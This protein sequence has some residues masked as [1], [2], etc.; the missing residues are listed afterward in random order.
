MGAPTKGGVPGARRIRLSWS[1]SRRRASGLIGSRWPELK[2]DP[3]PLARRSGRLS[4]AARTRHRGPFMLTELGEPLTFG[5]CNSHALSQRGAAQ[6]RHLAQSILS[7]CGYNA[8]NFWMDVGDRHA[9]VMPAAPQRETTSANNGSWAST[10]DV[11]DPPR[12]MQVMPC[13]VGDQGYAVPA[14]GALRGVCE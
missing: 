6:Q 8:W 11:V 9:D 14:D 1:L 10:A 4:V 2:Q 12:Q 5:S 7:P 13:C 3:V